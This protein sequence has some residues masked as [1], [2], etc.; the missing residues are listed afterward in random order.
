MKILHIPYQ[1]IPNQLGGTEIYVHSLCQEL[2]KQGIN[3]LIAAPT[4]ETSFNLHQFEYE[5]IEVHYFAIDPT[6]KF[7]YAYG[8]ADFIAES[9]F[10]SLLSN[11]EPSIVHFHA[12]SAAVSYLLLQACKEKNIKV[13]F[14]YHTPTVSCMRGT[15]MRNGTEP[16]NGVLNINR[17]TSCLLQK[18]G[19]NNA[20]SDVFS[21]IPLS[22]SEYFLKYQTKSNLFKGLVLKSL[23]V[24]SHQNTM[25][26]FSRVDRIVAVCNWVKE[27]IELNLDPKLK[28]IVVLNRQG[29]PYVNEVIKSTQREIHSSDNLLIKY[30]GRLDETKGILEF[31]LDFKKVESDKLVL[32]LF[33][34]VQ[35]R[36]TYFEKILK[37]VS[38][39]KRVI[40]KDSL[41]PEKIVEEMSSAD[42]VIVPSRWQETGPLVLLEAFSSGTPILGSN[43]G[44]ISEL[45]LNG[46]NGILVDINDEEP[47]RKALHKI[48][49]RPQILEELRQNITQVRT[50]AQVSIEMQDIYKSL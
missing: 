6:Q 31:L 3:S 49:A 17:C 37:A 40:L 5:G 21:K 1:F 35:N 14:T 27:V 48:L 36:S 2:Q 19:I 50:V 45:V 34:V 7:E 11:L 29:L 47:W 15:M 28:S 18:H 16:C 12:K 43:L 33:C 4:S 8:E 30:F 39:D 41:K 26:F 42:L 13:V 38:K 44:G 20:I 25:E 9:N 46:I 24:R 22:F 10:Q 23:I 32:E